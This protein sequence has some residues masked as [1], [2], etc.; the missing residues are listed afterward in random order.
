MC[1]QNAGCA[2]LRVGSHS[3]E[4]GAMDASA[5]AANLLDWSSALRS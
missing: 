2:E 1:L 3:I 5:A 4:A